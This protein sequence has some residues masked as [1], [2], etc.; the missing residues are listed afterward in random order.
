M[1]NLEEAYKKSQQEELPDLWNR[2]EAGLPE[3]K[4]KKS[5]LLSVLPYCSVAAAALLL[6]VLVIP[7]LSRQ[8]VNESPD[9]AMDMAS[10]D[11]Y[12]G[13]DIEW[14]GATSSS[15]TAEPEFEAE[16]TQ[17]ADISAEDKD[18]ALDRVEDSD[19]LNEAPIMED[20]TAPE[21]SYIT[22]QLL[23]SEAAE[24]EG[25]SIYTLTDADG[26]TFLAFYVN[27]TDSVLVIGES[28]I[29]TLREEAGEGWEY[30]IEGIE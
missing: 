2:I 19:S 20:T 12:N 13:D 11:F 29:F 25:G 14:S 22:V 17:N 23:V 15:Q 16:G 28:Y 4:K 3:K 21:V 9:T 8:S 7:P 1:K 10:Q 24:T 5:I 6:A 18:T 27:D 30:V 26:T